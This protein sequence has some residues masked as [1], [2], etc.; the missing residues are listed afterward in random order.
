M[1]R[2]LVTFYNTKIY[3]IIKN[4]FLASHCT[5]ILQYTSL[6]LVPT[7]GIEPD[8]PRLQLGALPFELSWHCIDG[9]C[10]IFLS[11]N[12]LVFTVARLLVL[13]RAN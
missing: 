12:M 1:V 13:V 9:M 11:Y 5:V 4:S 8:H 2:T 10:T 3:N 7:S 6:D